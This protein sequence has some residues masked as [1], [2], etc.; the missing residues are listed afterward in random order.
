MYFRCVEKKYCN[1]FK[2]KAKGCQS[3][4][5]I[6]VKEKMPYKTVLFSLFRPCNH[7]NLQA[8]IWEPLTDR[9]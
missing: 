4:K 9:R 8:L 2:D 6:N 3:K 7:F 1:N 5:P